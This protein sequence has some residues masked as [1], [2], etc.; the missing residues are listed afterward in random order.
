MRLRNHVTG[1]RELSMSRQSCAWLCAHHD[2]VRVRL[3]RHGKLRN[4]AVKK[5]MANR[6]V[7]VATLA[8]VVFMAPRLAA[9]ALVTF[10]R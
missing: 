3:V 6:L 10:G 1:D 4:M 5:L 9:Q 8:F 2:Q 7:F